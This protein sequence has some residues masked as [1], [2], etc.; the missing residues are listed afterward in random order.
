MTDANQGN[1]RILIVTPEVTYLPYN[2]GNIANYLQ[3]RMP[4]PGGHK[5]YL[6]YGTEANSAGFRVS[7]KRVERILKDS[8]Y[9]FGIDWLGNSYPAIPTL[10]RPGVPGFRCRCGFC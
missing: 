9:A 8:G 6:D 3:A 10:K 4:E 1:P 2:M 7:Q 5:I